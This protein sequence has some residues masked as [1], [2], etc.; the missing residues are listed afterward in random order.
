MKS[1]IMALALTTSVFAQ[2]SLLTFEPGTAQIEGVTISKTATI[3]KQDG[4]PSTIKMDL[5]GAGLRE[6]SVLVITA[7]VYV[8][9]LFS[10]NKAAFARNETALDSLV[11]NSTS[12]AL[13][14]T[15]KRTVSAS[16]LAVSFREALEANGYEIDAELTNLLGLVESSADGVSGKSI[17]MLMTKSADAKTNIYYEDTDGQLKSFQGSEALMKKIGSIWLGKPADDG[18]ASLKES[19]LKPIY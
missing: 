5:L 15:M 2:A 10:N 8:L 6:K 18:L 12:V 7:K 3:N 19:L 9:E 11:K 1:V 16:K 14:I 13:K 4:T 17:S